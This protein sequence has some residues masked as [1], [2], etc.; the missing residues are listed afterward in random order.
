MELSKLER[1]IG[2]SFKSLPLLER[3]LTHRSWAHENLGSEAEE[4]MREA[5]NES[6]EFVGDSVLGLV[7][8]EELFRR[9]PSVSEGDL[10]LMKHRLVS[11]TTLA[12]IGERL[13]LGEFVRMSRGEEKTGGRDKPAI[14][15]NTLE[16]IIA[17][18]FFDSGY[19]HARNFVTALFGD[20]IAKA[21]PRAS[22]DYK[23]L[24]QETLQAAKLHAPVY[25]LVSSEGPPHDRTFYVK[26]RWE[27]GE[28]SGFGSSI[29]AAEMMAAKE[30]L[31]AI[32]RNGDLP[33]QTE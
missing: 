27:L 16:A 4:T 5:E 13:N 3:A 21:T 20:E 12:R 9:N 19:V 18:V 22:L 24:L 17:A 32:E 33:K 15:A 2:Y 14:L 8:A 31:L 23:T 26:A 6:L 28:T 10:T 11:T 1:T 29:K 25:S 30:A 7:I